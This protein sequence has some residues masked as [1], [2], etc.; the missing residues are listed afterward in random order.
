MQKICLRMRSQT[1]FESSRFRVQIRPQI[2]VKILL[3][4]SLLNSSSRDQSLK[5][6]QCK[7]TNKGP[8]LEGRSLSTSA[9]QKEQKAEMDSCCGDDIFRYPFATNGGQRACCGTRTY[10]TELLECCSQERG[11]ILKF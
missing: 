8:V 2:E 11:R 3:K 7:K 6:D 4:S 9:G 1:C 10:S 5:A